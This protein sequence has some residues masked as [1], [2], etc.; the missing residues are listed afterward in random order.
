MI[1][2]S[3]FEEIDRE[4]EIHKLQAEIDKEK[5]KLNVKV[6]KNSLSP[7]NIGVEVALALVQKLLYGRALQR[8]FRRK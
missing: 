3:S 5:M 1:I 8:L 2:Y 7:T 6:I 4:L